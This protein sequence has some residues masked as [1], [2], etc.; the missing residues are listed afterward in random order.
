M[1]PAAGNWIAEP[2]R[3]SIIDEFSRFFLKPAHI[4]DLLFAVVTI[5]ANR[6]V[7]S[8]LPFEGWQHQAAEQ[9]L[10][11][12]LLLEWLKICSS[13]HDGNLRELVVLMRNDTADSRLRDLSALLVSAD[14]F[15]GVED[16]YYASVLLVLSGAYSMWRSRIREDVSQI[17]TRAWLRVASTERFSLRSPQLTVPAISAACNL[18]GN[19]FEKAAKILLAARH[20]VWTRAGD[21]VL[22]RLN[23]VAEGTGNTPTGS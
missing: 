2:Y 12:A 10:S 20:A 1:L 19:G 23:S 14:E 16:L 11:D 22:S 6:K 13:K 21:S 4:F 7:L 15:S 5:A 8:S 17:I 3:Q 18:S 9:N